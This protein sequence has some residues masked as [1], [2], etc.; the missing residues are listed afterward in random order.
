MK[1]ASQPMT[2]GHASK[3]S[4]WAYEP[5][6]DFYNMDTSDESINELLSGAYRIVQ[7]SSEVYGFY[8]VGESAQVPSGHEA[9]AYLSQRNV[10]DLGIGMRP[11]FTG[12]GLGSKFLAHVLCQIVSDCPCANVRLTVAT[13]NKRAIRL[14]ERFGFRPV[15][16]FVHAGVT[17][18]VM[19]RPTEDLPPEQEWSLR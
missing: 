9:G 19:T 6:Y 15:S 12:Q 2:L 10:V 5:P 1:F 18:Q 17:F 16:E 7:S 14:Y 3:I 4:R 8:C 11:E 13:F